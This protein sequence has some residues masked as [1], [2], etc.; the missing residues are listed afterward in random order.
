MQKLSPDALVAELKSSMEWSD[1]VLAI[2]QHV[3]KE[4]GQ[5]LCDKPKDVLSV[6]QVSI[7]AARPTMY[8]IACASNM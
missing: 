5:A 2:V 4:E 3:W 7:C 1:G 8:R 6:G